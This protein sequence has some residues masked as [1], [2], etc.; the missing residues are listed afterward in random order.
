MIFSQHKIL[1]TYI[2]R[3]ISSDY[4]KMQ[5]NPYLKFKSKRGTNLNRKYLTIEEVNKI[6]EYKFEPDRNCP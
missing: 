5:D 1:K 4:M 3:A 2:N 6:E